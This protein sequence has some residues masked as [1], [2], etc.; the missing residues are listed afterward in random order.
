MGAATRREL[1]ADSLKFVVL[2]LATFGALLLGGLIGDFFAVD[3]TAG[4][5]TATT[6]AVLGVLLMI[7][8]GTF[9]LGALLLFVHGIFRRRNYVTPSVPTEPD[10]RRRRGPYVGL[11]ARSITE[12]AVTIRSRYAGESCR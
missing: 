9:T 12:E 6:A 5:W 3:P 1:F 8:T 10:A 11:A 4:T 2:A 7:L